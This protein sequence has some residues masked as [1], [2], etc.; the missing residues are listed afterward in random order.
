MGTLGRIKRGLR[1][2]RL[3][4][5]GSAAVE[6]TLIL[7][8]MLMLYIGVMEGSTLIIVDRKVQSVAGAVGDLVARADEQLPRSDLRDYFRASSG[9]M[10]PYE[11]NQ[12]LQTVTAVKILAGEKVEVVWQAKYQNEI[13]SEVAKAALPTNYSLPD[14]MMAVTTVGDM[15]IAA[16]A[17][18]AF[19]PLFGIVFEQAINLY[20]SNFF[21]PRF[22]DG[23][24]LVN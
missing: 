6:F 16:E 4:E 20:R 21:M 23:I 17:S 14:Q 24:T 12:V 8:I 15:V 5:R 1:R 9:I 18:Y 3:S 22:G 10:A 13:Y 19:R 7:P 2:L 11:A